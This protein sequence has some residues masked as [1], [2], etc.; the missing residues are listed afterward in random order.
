MPLSD[1]LKSAGTCPFCRQKADIISCEHPHQAEW[2]EMV[3]LAA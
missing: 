2:N 3:N 1:L